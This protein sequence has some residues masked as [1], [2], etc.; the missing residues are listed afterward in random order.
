M[1]GSA[2]T[3]RL[4]IV[5]L[6]AQGPLARAE[7]SPF[8]LRADLIAFP[9]DDCVFPS[10]LLEQVATHFETDPDLAGLTGR[11]ATEDGRSRVVGSIPRF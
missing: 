1:T 7:R 8:L 4:D 9:D 11:A 6:E 2:A 5:R 3:A 10:D